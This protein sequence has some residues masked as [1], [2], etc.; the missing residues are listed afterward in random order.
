MGNSYLPSEEFIAALPQPTPRAPWKILFSACL[1]GQPCGY[2]GSSY[3]EHP[4]AQ[5]LM[6]LPNIEAV[7][8]CP[9]HFSFGTPRALCNIHGGDGFDVLHG[10][11]RVLTEE[12]EDWTEGILAAAR[13]MLTLAR[14]RYVLFAV[15]MDIS[16]ACGSQVIYDG[17]RSGPE[18]RYQ[19]GAGVCTAMLASSDI[20]VMS[21]RDFKTLDRILQRADETYISHA[22]V[23]DH[24]ETEWYQGYFAQP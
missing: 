5:R 17:H 4:G 24:H 16:A 15:M 2:D 23:Q 1:G 20:P 13:R 18:V 3:G 12:G 14:E 6:Q 19:R 22:S 11:A 7:F 9:E 21:Q 8:F 10:T